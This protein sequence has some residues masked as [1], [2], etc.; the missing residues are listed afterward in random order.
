ELSRRLGRLPARVTL[1]GVEVADVTHGADLSP[2]VARGV[3]EAIAR[4]REL[5][6]TADVGGDCVPR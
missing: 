3:P 1:V 2:E 4:V 6:E 5:L